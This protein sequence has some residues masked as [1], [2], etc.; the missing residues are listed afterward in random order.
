M[1]DKFINN[2]KIIIKKP[3]LINLVILLTMTILMFFLCE[4][5]LRIYFP[6]PEHKDKG[7]LLRKEWNRDYK[8]SVFI[9]NTEVIHYSV[10]T[11][12]NSWGLKNKEIDFYK[13]KNILRISMFG[14]SFTYGAGLPIHETLPSQLEKRLNVEEKDSIG[15]QVLN[16]GACG[17]N[18]FEETMYAL[19]YGLKFKPDII[20]IV[21]LYNDIEMNGYA[22]RDFE[23]FTKH[24]IVPKREKM[25]SNKVIGEN[26]GVYQ[27]KRSITMRFWNFY[28][29][30]KQKSRF[31]YI[32]GIRTKRLLQNFG[33]NLKK[34]EEIIFSDL[35]S[36]GFKLSFNSLKF[37][38]K[39]LKKMDIEFYIVI[40]PP[41]QKLED[42]YYN[43]LINK[44]VENF[45]IDNNI[46]CLN[47]FDYFRGQEPSKLHM[48]GFDVH[49]NRY[50]NE[51]AS[52]A[53]AKYLKQKTKL[54]KRR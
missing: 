52:E 2:L 7:Q 46:Q 25:V 23:Y 9:P 45:C 30:L 10:P 14:D 3:Y 51:I 35:E 22:L 11:K 50:A 33:L 27:G 41:L 28:D 37:I 20:I 26:I 17:M 39:Q 54:F 16:F 44:K 48:S 13:S 49:P 8:K 12:I 42:D 5:F 4:L 19:N 32:V 18:T 38:N 53:I 15:V 29:K 24:G 47:L 40:Y 6:M 31:I 43:D 36:G 1:K 34:S 21:W